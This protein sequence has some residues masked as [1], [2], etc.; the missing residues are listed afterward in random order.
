MNPPVFGS[1]PLAWLI[2]LCAVSL[3]V[4]LLAG[5]FGSDIAGYQSAGANAFSRSALGHRGFVELLRELKIP[6]SLGLSRPSDASRK[7]VLVI[8][9]PELGDRDDSGYSQWTNYRNLFR[10]ILVVLPKWEGA[11][12]PARPDWLQAAWL[13]PHA[14]VERVLED[15]G[16]PGEVVR[17]ADTPHWTKTL[18]GFPAPDL[19]HPQFLRSDRVIPIWKAE[20][21]ILAAMWRPPSPFLGTVIVL[22]DPDLLSNHGLGRGG[23]AGHAVDLIRRL[24]GI[25]N[26]VLV[27]ETLHGYSAPRSIW[28]GFFRFPLSLVLIQVLITG[29]VLVWLAMG[30]FGPP[31]PLPPP[32]A[33]GYS[34][35]VNNTADLLLVG[36]YDL[37]ILKRFYET[38]VAGV[39]RAFHLD[40][41]LDPAQVRDRLRR[42][43]T[44]RGV[45]VD[46]DAVHDRIQDPDASQ[47]AWVLRTA[48]EIHRW[49]QEMTHGL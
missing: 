16:I 21:G 30:R 33:P 17:P 45:T 43:G 40:P 9:E 32:H 47:P 26:G 29:G 36:G 1:R 12:D 37:S 35:L 7:S 27:D 28:R 25:E 15:L 14:R 5:I 11:P 49:K 3:V 4:A 39:A 8:A 48:G 19:P 20:E 23:N 42:I 41:R 6:V 34:H 44:S 31:L 24:G 10:S 46:L 18:D 22:A 38:T 13:A 2:G